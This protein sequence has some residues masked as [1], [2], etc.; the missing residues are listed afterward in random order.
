MGTIKNGILGG[1]SGKVG[2]VVGG[3]WNGVDYMRSEA[4]T[5]KNPQSARQMK[6][7]ARFMFAS[8]FLRQ[9]GKYLDLGFQETVADMSAL[10]IAIQL[11]LKNGAVTEDGTGFNIDYSKLVLSKG[12]V[13]PI[14]SAYCGYYKNNFYVE[15][16]ENGYMGNATNDDLT[17]LAFVDTTTFEV[18]TVLPPNG[19]VRRKCYYGAAVPALCKGHSIACFMS[20]LSP[21][22]KRSSPSRLI[23]IEPIPA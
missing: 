7:R 20:F 1:F 15:W 6:Q 5:V 22:G 9:F 2:T 18:R 16:I 3:T 11:N 10:N 17:M 13:L 19:Y 21:D 12:T 8:K 23:G 4:Q 14:A